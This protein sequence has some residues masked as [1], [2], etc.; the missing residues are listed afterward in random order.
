VKTSEHDGQKAQNRLIPRSA[1]SDE[2]TNRASEAI[3]NIEMMPEVLSPS[4]DPQLGTLMVMEGLISDSQ[5]QDALRTQSQLEVYRPFGQIL[6]DHKVISIKQLS[7]F[8]DKHHKRARLGEILLKSKTI[9]S[10]QLEIAL[11]HQKTTG[12]PLGEM[13]IKLNYVSEE[14]MRQALCKHLNIPFIDLDKF[15]FDAGLRKLINKSYAKNNRVVPIAMI[16]NSITLAM[17]DP[18]NTAV[19]KELRSSTGLTINV[20][21]STSAKIHH[22]FAKLYGEELQGEQ[23][24]DRGQELITEQESPELG[25]SRYLENINKHNVLMMQFARLSILQ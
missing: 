6:V 14:G 20:V 7:T 1:A 10:E 23:E 8:I 17:D 24:V 9:T 5:L 21:T 13:L 12:L 19:V 4:D 22:A 2:V 3:A 15:T 11:S 18:T 25:K 16:G